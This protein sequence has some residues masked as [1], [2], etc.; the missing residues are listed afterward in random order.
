MLKLGLCR[1]VVAL[2]HSALKDSSLPLRS[3]DEPAGDHTAVFGQQRRGV[4]TSVLCCVVF[5]HSRAL[6]RARACKATCVQVPLRLSSLCPLQV[7]IET[8]TPQS[9]LVVSESC[10]LILFRWMSSTLQSREKVQDGSWKS[11]NLCACLQTQKNRQKC[12][13]DMGN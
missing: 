10:N 11:W 9:S 1:S 3:C 4:P 8:L 12:N 5:F 7:V 6:T 13:C 2:V